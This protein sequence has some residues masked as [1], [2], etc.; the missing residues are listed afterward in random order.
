M[1]RRTEDHHPRQIVHEGTMCHL[2]ALLL[3]CG[4]GWAC[5]AGCGMVCADSGVTADPLA[6][7]PVQ[8]RPRGSSST[9]GC[10]KRRASFRS[11]RE[12]SWR[13]QRVCSTRSATRPCRW[14][15]VMPCARGLSH[16]MANPPLDGSPRAETASH[17]AYGG[18]RY[19]A[20]PPGVTDVEAAGCC[21]ATRVPSCRWCAQSPC[22]LGDVRR[23]P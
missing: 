1:R 11:W 16:I 15:S 4:E 13:S 12:S 7:S 2:W 5:A 9:P 20:S 8:M 23:P 6:V 22:V 17:N 14:R 10:A 21:L 3:T 19:A 18:G